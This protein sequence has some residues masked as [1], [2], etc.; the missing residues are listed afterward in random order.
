MKIVIPAR[1][2]S[3][4]IPNKNV[5]LLNGKPLISYAIETC[6]KVTP[7]VY[8]STDCSTIS[9]VSL[10]CGAKVISRPADLATDTSRTEDAIEHF[11]DTVDGVDEFACVQATTPM[12]DSDS[13]QKGFEKL[14]VYDSV[15]SVVEKTEYLW[16]KHHKPINFSKLGRPR[17]QN[18]DTIYSE[19]G[20]FYITTKDCFMKG[21]C[22]YD[23]RVGLV[24][25]NALSSFEIDTKDDWDIVSKCI[26]LK[27]HI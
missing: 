20:A 2:G 24:T 9:D 10:S 5:K 19:N 17:T 25:M 13:L 12:L 26:M 7:E 21:K 23:G 8:V 27:N 11:L 16:D 18:I 3:K 6:L 22:L 1:G 4:R 15:I 14:R